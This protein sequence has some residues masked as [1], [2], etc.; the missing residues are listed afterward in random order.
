MRILFKCK[1][2]ELICT[3]K[4]STSKNVKHILPSYIKEIILKF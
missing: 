1:V 3:F 2:T 4:Y